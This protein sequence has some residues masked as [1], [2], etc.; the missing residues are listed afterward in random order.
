MARRASATLAR[1]GLTAERPAARAASRKIPTARWRHLMTGRDERV[2]AQTGS[3]S[4]RILPWV[5]PGLALADGVLHLSL[6][7][8]LFRG[9]FFANTLSV[10]FLLDF[11]GYVVLT[12]AFVLSPRWLG[13]KRWLVNAAMILFVAIALVDWAA[14]GG[15]NPRGLGYL[16]KVVEVL[17]VAA[18]AAHLQILRRPAAAPYALQ[19]RG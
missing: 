18:L 1:V 6:D 8:I 11:L 3:T 4:E 7:L 16:S 17:L 12:A 15:P 13:S 9:R 10:L 5:I 19:R 14:R 2:S